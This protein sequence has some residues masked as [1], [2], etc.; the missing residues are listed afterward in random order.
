[1][2][3]RGEITDVVSHNIRGIPS[4]GAVIEWIVLGIRREPPEVPHRHRATPL[5]QQVQKA[6]GSKVRAVLALQPPAGGFRRLRAAPRSSP[7]WGAAKSRRY[8]WGSLLCPIRPR[9]V[10]SGVP[11]APLRSARGT[12]WQP[13]GRRTGQ[14]G[15]AGL[16]PPRAGLP[17]HIYHAGA[18]APANT[19]AAERSAAGVFAGARAPA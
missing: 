12:A 5:P 16:P 3:Q 18:R 15:Y 1:V 14:R 6:A 4:D 10:L 8:A 11:P 9:R 13:S 7:P 17:G 2:L 19:P